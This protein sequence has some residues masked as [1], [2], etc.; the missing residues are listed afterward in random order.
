M[1]VLRMKGLKVC[2][3]LKWICVKIELV[4]LFFIENKNV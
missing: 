4:N 3:Y 1:C 2:V